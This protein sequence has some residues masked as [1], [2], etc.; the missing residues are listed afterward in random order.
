MERAARGKLE[1]EGCKHYNYQ[2]RQSRE[3]VRPSKM[4]WGAS[5]RAVIGGWSARMR[6]LFT[7]LPIQLKFTSTVGKSKEERSERKRTG[8]LRHYKTSRTG[9]TIPKRTHG[10]AKLGKW[11]GG[12]VMVTKTYPL[13]ILSASG[14]C[15]DAALSFQ[16]LF[17][18]ERGGYN[19]RVD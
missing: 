8:I 15:I 5:G 14:Y 4:E 16:K 9:L 3:W 13:E 2:P 11:E 10:Q 1:R 17:W 18:K 12:N 19:K 6:E 7:G